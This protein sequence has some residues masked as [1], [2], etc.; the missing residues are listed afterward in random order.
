MRFTRPG[1]AQTPAGS[2]PTSRTNAVVTVS[3]VAAS[4]VA[5]RSF[6]LF[7]TTPRL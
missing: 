2:W 3:G 5:A 4:A 6:A 7:L 1:A